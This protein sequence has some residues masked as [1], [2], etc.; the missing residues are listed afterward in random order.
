MGRAKIKRDILNAVYKM[1]FVCR[2]WA[3]Y[4]VLTGKRCPVSHEWIPLSNGEID[5]A[6]NEFAPYSAN[7]KSIALLRE[8]IIWAH[9]H[10]CFSPEEY[11]IFT[12]FNR[13]LDDFLSENMM[14]Y[15]LIKTEGI[16]RCDEL[17]DKLGMYNKL[18]EFYKRDVLSLRT[19]NDLPA[20]LNFA[21]SHSVAIFKPNSS[22]CG[23]GIFI[24][25]DLKSFD[26]KEL[27]SQGEW[28]IEEL[29]EQNPE[30]K[31]LNPSSVQTIRICTI[32]NQNGCH[33]INCAIRMGRK[34]SVVDNTMQGGVYASVD[35]DTGRINSVAIDRYLNEYSEHPDSHVSLSNWQVP[36]W[37]ELLDFVVRVH[38]TVPQFKYV[39]WDMALTDKGWC[40]VEANWGELLAQH[41][42]GI[43]VKKLFLKEIRA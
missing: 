20:Y 11:F 36:R 13:N 43:G 26:V 3:K 8:R 23:R 34:G 24:E 4:I 35:V 40:V 14:N 1:S 7:N 6:I 15:L 28:C 29:I 12:R 21:N 22:S 31:K 18:K 41:C 38:N 17:E 5:K 33:I 30:M 25:Q 39:G 32:L 27:I 9:L 16:A 37:N 10:H 2:L 19:K 42:S